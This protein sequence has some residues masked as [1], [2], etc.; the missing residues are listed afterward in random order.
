[1][2]RRMRRPRVTSLRLSDAEHQLLADRA[3]EA[4]MKPSEFLRSLLVKA[5]QPAVTYSIHPTTTISTSAA[6]ASRFVAASLQRYLRRGGTFT[7]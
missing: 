1:M 6:E 5:E 2:M 4:G 7:A 3:A